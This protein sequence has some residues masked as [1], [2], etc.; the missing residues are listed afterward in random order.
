MYGG[1]SAGIVV[2]APRD[3]LLLDKLI[4]AQWPPLWSSGQKSELQIQRAGFDSGRYQI[5]WEVLSLERVPLS[6]VSTT[7]E[8]LDRK[9]S[10]SGLQSPEYSRRD[11]SRW[12]RGTLY[13]QKLALTSQTSGGRSVGIV[14][15]RT[16]ATELIFLDSRSAGVEIV[17]FYGSLPV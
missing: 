9:N 11:P 3:T 16:Q 12:R 14:H 13:P 8:L 4:V 17:R 7:E 1:R 6:L 15:S 2:L 5:S 10:V